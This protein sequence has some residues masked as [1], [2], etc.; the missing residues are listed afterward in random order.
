M[1]LAPLPF[2]EGESSGLESLAGSSPA[3]INSLTD[4]AGTRRA[5]PGVTAW[6]DFP[7]GGDSPIDGMA[8][9]GD[10]LIFVTRDRYL[11]AWQPIGPGSSTGSVVALSNGYG[12]TLLDGASRPQFLPMRTKVIVVGGG[13]P[14]EWFGSG[15]SQRLGVNIAGYTA[16]QM[17]FITSLGSKLVSSYPDASGIIRW[18]GNGEPLGSELW[19]AL[20]YAEAEAKPDK[21]VAVADNANE[22][23]AFGSETLQVFTPD[24]TVGFAPVRTLNVGLLA[25]YSLIKVDDMFAF[26]DRERRFLLTDG[27]S[28]SD[29]DSVL[30]KPIEARLRTLGTDCWGFRMRSDRWDAC[31]WMFPT[32]GLGYI[33][34]R[35]DNSWSEWR[36]FGP[37]GYTAPSITSAV[38][39]P[40]KELFLLGLSNGQ[41]ARLDAGAYTD[42]GSIIKVELVT[43]FVTHDTDNRKRC[44]SVKF[45]FRRG[46]TTSSSDPR[47]EISYRDDLGAYCQPSIYS[48]GLAGDYDATI[49][50][51]SE[52]V[53]RRRQWRIQYTAAAE[54]SFVGAKEEFD[55]LAN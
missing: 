48:L 18:S 44:R 45:T 14:Q 29:Q 54:F 41:I 37:A 8:P 52:G 31:V 30:S 26:L 49:E 43:G 51:R 47:V 21:L 20:N 40:E 12:P 33:W 22:L 36:A 6:A 7:T 28:F 55:V 19:D 25:P 38:Y 42:L 16:P 50:M 32:Q 39:W 13:Y 10:D 3:M 11:W 24:A 53:Y 27:R 1:P 23:F 15:L 46:Q 34:N 5:R 4:L 17:S 2:A 35:R 9:W